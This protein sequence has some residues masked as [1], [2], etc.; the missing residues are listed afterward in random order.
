MNAVRSAVESPKAESPAPISGRWRDLVVP[1][2]ATAVVTAILVSLGTW[3]VH[4]LAWKL[5]LIATVESRTHLAPIDAPSLEATRGRDMADLDYRPVRLA[6]RFL[7]G[8]EAHVAAMLGEPRGRFG[9]PGVWV[10][11]PLER[12]DGSIVWVNRGFVPNGAADVAAPSGN[13][14]IEGLL[15]RPEPRGAFV[16]AD[17][18]ARNMWFVRDP[19]ILTAGL[20]LDPARAA[21]FTVDAA[22]SSTP[23]GGLPQA[24]ETRLSFEN[25]HLGYILT[26]YGLA[27]TCVGVF[28]VWARG[29]LRPPRT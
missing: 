28:V 17:D 9:G 4:R 27:A 19:A 22:A 24:G 13:V 5:D 20:G 11:A 8:I 2:S 16:P 7:P 12:P 1:G 10:M 23:P 29:R 21:P 15:R 3:Q 6:G 26:W 25:N 14:E 18:R